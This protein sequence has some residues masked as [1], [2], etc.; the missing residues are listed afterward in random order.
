MMMMILMMMIILMVQG[1]DPISV[2]NRLGLHSIPHNGPLQMIMMTVMMMMMMV[3]VT[4]KI[5]ML[6]III[7]SIIKFYVFLQKLFLPNAIDIS[8]LL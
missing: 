7:I 5:M 3:V 2:C 1:N 4:S 8:F 6:S